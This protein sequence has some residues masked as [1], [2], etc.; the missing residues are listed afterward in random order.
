[1]KKDSYS[2]FSETF[3]KMLFVTFANTECIINEEVEY[4]N[5]YIK[6]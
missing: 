6:F 2:H 5:F 4:N 1:M 3:L